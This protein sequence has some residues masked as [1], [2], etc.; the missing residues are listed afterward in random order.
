M[1]MRKCDSSSQPRTSCGM[2]QYKMNG[3]KRLTWFTMKKQVR[4]GLKST[5]VCTFTLAPEKNAMRRHRPRCSQSCL[6][7]EEID[8]VH[9]EKTGA[10]RVEIHRG[11]HLHFGARKKRDAPA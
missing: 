9:H 11:L 10:L 4:C 1:G 5:A 7:V 2:A 6:R 3:S 8:V